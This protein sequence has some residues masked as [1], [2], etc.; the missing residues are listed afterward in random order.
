MKKL[1][2]SFIASGVG[3]PIKKGTLDFL[4]QSYKDLVAELAQEIYA[5][6]TLEDYPAALRGCTFTVDGSGNYTLQPG[7]VFIPAS[8]LQGIPGEE[9]TRTGELFLLPEVQTTPTNV[10]A[11]DYPILALSIS[12]YSP[13]DN[14]ADPVTFSDSSSHNVHQIRTLTLTH[15]HYPDVPNFCC[16]LDFNHPATPPN[17][18]ANLLFPSQL[19]A[20]ALSGSFFKY[21]QAQPESPSGGDIIYIA[22]SPGLV[23]FNPAPTFNISSS[24]MTFSFSCQLNLTSSAGAC[25]FYI[26]VNGAYVTG[27]AVSLSSAGGQAFSVSIVGVAP[28]TAGDSVTV[29]ATASDGAVGYVQQA[30]LVCECFD[31]H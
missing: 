11:N 10:S 25:N 13:S 15:G 9:N 24:A 14:T 3:F 16:Y 4:Q 21:A 20:Y 5:N 12:Y 19:S 29:T 8:I 27:T 6:L 18:V 23:I 28:Y 30:H 2:T 26:N 22:T 1:D 17:E 7:A 31:A